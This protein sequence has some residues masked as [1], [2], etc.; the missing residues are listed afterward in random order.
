MPSTT[1][2]TTLSLFVLLGACHL[3][4]ATPI[5]DTNQVANSSFSGAGGMAKG[6]GVNNGAANAADTGVMGTI[7]RMTL[8]SMNSGN[9]GN[10]GSANS[11]SALT[12]EQGTA[13]QMLDTTGAGNVASTTNSAFSGAGGNADGGTVTGASGGLIKINS[14]KSASS[15]HPVGRMADTFFFGTGNGGNGGKANSGNSASGVAGPAAKFVTI[16]NS[17]AKV[18]R[19]ATLYLD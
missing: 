4:T 12:G 19:R 14:G 10:G 17:K 9:G 1:T 18:V 3:A 15:H 11:G 5:P 2:T 8:I 7:E 6:G 13:A 16:P